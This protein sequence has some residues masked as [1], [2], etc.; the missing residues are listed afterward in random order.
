MDAINI[1]YKNEQKL[2]KN[3]AIFD[4]ESIR[5]KENSYKQTETTTWVGKHVPI[6]VSISSNVIPEPIFLCNAN[7]HHLISSFITALE[8]IATY[9]KAQMKMIFFEVETAIKIKLGAIL[10]QFNQGRNRAERLSSF[11][12]ESIVEG[13]EKYLSTQFLQMQKNQL[14]DLHDYFK[15]YFSVLRVF[16]FNSAKY[17]I[18]LIKSY[19]RPLLVNEQVIEPTVLEKT[20]HIVSFKFGDIQILDIM[21][22]LGGATR[23]DCSLKAYK[24]KE[25]MD[26]IPYEWFDCP[27][28]INIKELPPCDSFCS[29][30]RNNNPLEKD[31]NDFQKL[32]NSGLTTE[33]AVAKLRMD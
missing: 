5:V 2:F 1:P 21:N 9:S 15:S 4:F 26:F 22:F 32:V 10:E 23:L 16:V 12:D 19:L 13:E 30:L 25:T 29:I 17:D 33:Q 11:V 3:L 28:K 31:Y 6:S 7:P 18:N 24:T 14:I 8:E 20:N 27:E